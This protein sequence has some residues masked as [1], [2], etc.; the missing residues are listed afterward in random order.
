[1]PDFE[2]IH[3]GGDF[4]ELPPEGRPSRLRRDGRDILEKT[5][6]T[7]A[8]AE[9]H[10][11]T[12]SDITDFGSYSPVGHTHVAADIIGLSVGNQ[13]QAVTDGPQTDWL[14]AWNG[15][16]WETVVSRVQS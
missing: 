10:T 4:R 7:T 16:F 9:D 3:P 13:P 14:V 6:I 15:S 5:I 2:P 11:H 12:E 1:M 8:P